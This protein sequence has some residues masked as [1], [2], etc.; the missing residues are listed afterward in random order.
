MLNFILGVI[1]GVVI[2]KPHLLTFIVTFVQ[3][4]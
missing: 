2:C 3:S 1:A 4:L